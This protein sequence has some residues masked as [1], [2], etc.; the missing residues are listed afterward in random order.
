MR[1][2][3]QGGSSRGLGS[4][5]VSPPPE[6][7]GEVRGRRNPAPEG[8]YG[9]P[10]PFGSKTYHWQPAKLLRDKL[11][12][13]M[14]DWGFHTIEELDKWLPEREWVRA[15]LDLIQFGWSFDRQG[16]GL[17]LRR[18][19]PGEPRQSVV[20][21]LSGLTVANE[22]GAEVA[23]PSVEEAEAEG[24]D[25]ASPFPPGEDDEAVASEDEMVLDEAR[26]MILAAPEFVTET[27]GILARKGRGKTY[28]AMVLA[29]ELL[30]SEYEIPFVVIDPTGCWYGLLS[31]A[32]GEPSENRIVLLGGERGHYSL[33]AAA[34]RLAA[35][36]VVECRP[37]PVILD[38]SLMS[39]EEQHG[40]VADFVS[41][42]YLK[43]RTALHVFVDE[44]DIFAPQKLDKSSKHHGRCLSAMDN[45]VRRGRFRGIGDTLVSQRPAVINKNLLSQVG[46]MFFLQ[47]IAPQDLDA[48]GDWLHNNIRG[49]AREACRADIPVLGRGVAYF[50]RGG[51]KPMFR[52][53]TV[54]P[55][56]T[57]DS[58]HTPSFKEVVVVAKIGK[59]SDEDRK[60]LDACYGDLV[61]QL[62]KVVD[63]LV[64][65]PGGEELGGV[66]KQELAASI[67]VQHGD[68]G[69]DPAARLSEEEK[70]ALVRASQEEDFEEQRALPE[71]PVDLFEDDRSADLGEEDRDE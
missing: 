10:S 7:F 17:R 12:D 3:F 38:L 26:T 57:F 56:T 61:T 48:V 36:A 31:D 59:L 45:M 44:A 58:S 33:P 6:D 62:E 60:V 52:K 50:L 2:G 20:D 40:F 53:F 42:L 13:R 49:E 19:L 70:A 68:D 67:G 63:T 69:D 41:E 28:L 16:K 65:G 34:G 25:G 23:S 55:K 8:V 37:L 9:A 32:L 71:P 14:C 1:P 11:H 15:M 18:A 24:D 64:E 54:R 21:L 27:C 4:G 35:R 51:D 47:M 66:E 46:S 39:A 43:N 29:E 30:K 5:L 22:A